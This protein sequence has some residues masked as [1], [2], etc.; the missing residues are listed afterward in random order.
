MNLAVSFWHGKSGQV[1]ESL[2]TGFI[3][4][5]LLLRRDKLPMGSEWTYEIKLDGALD[6][7]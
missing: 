1:G 3:E 6:S 2:R 5:M 4:P 7:T